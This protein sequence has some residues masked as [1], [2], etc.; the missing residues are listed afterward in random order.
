M[1]KT[2][3]FEPSSDV[4]VYLEDVSV[5]YRVPTE[6]VATIKEYAIRRI[7]RRIKYNHFLAL[8]K[9]NFS[10]QQGE[11]FGIIGRNG[12]GKSTLLKVI[13]RVLFPTSGRV[14]INGSVSPLLELGAGF[15]PE[16]T[17]MENILL[18]GTLLGHKRK[19][20]Q[21]KIP[22]IIEFSEIGDFINAPIR[23]YSSGMVARLGFSIATAWIPEILILDEVLSVGDAAFAKKCELRMKSIRE[24]GCTILL[25]TH[26][27]EM[28]HSICKRAMLLNHGQVAGIGPEAEICDQ[29]IKLLAG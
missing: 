16:L 25:V 19:E 12:A 14:W 17:G 21:E 20:I 3:S 6:K 8:N 29:Y 11:I 2:E 24:S 28:I 4:A 27:I 15:H 10:V 23:T 9:I 26:N 1:S 18:N 7:Q 5:S 13:S 22:Q